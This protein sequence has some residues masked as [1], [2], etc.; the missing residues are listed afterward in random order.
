M[1][2]KTITLHRINITKAY[3]MYE[4]GTAWDLKPWKGNTTYYEGETLES[5][6]F[7]LPEGYTVGKNEFDQ[8]EIYFDG[9]ICELV[10]DN[11]M[12]ALVPSPYPNGTYLKRVGK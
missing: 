3:Q 6:E 12:P 8:T 2:D 10:T 11:D 4:Q 7:I 5:A 1:S 9:E